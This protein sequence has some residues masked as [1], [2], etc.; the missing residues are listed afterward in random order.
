MKTL[1]IRNF[2]P[3][4]EAVIEMGRMNLIIGLQSSGKSCVMM[5]ACYCSWVEKRIALRQS[6]K[7]FNDGSYFLDMMTLYYHTK[8]Y[9]HDDTFIKYESEFMVF[10]Y[11]HAD[12]AFEHQWKNLHWRYRRPKVSY[13]PAERNVVSLVTNWSRLETSYDNILDFKEDW[14][15][16]RKFMKKERNI[17][18][19]GISYEYN[20]ASGEDNIV[21]SDGKRLELANSSS[22]MQSLVPQVVHLDY[23]RRGIYSAERL[24]TD[25]TYAT[26]QLMNNL[27]D[28]LY[29]RNY[30]KENGDMICEDPIVVHLGGKDYT[31]RSQKVA[32]Q[33][34]KEAG[35]LMRT[36]HAEV[37]LEEPESNL[38][39]PT[40]FQLM[41]MIKE[42]G[43]DKK[44][45]N[46]FFIATHSPY[47]LSYLLQEDLKDFKLFLT[48]PA[49]DGYYYVKTATSD[50]IQQIY[51]NGS[52]AFFNFEAFTN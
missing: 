31:F 7:E 19:T 45:K 3:L 16:A 42:M 22:G 17:L 12:K 37:F 13:V 47:V 32:N 15:V 6:A 27:L 40:Q 24:E 36:D 39:P 35:F 29:K 21:T 38:F 50:D 28:I 14:D 41:N 46:F 34:T 48:Y 4:K 43:T 51:D 9:V 23:L 20:D 1:T 18:E 8:G 44:H 25:K 52:D 10:S 30:G 26:K 33:F 2:G 11:D 5:V 49:G